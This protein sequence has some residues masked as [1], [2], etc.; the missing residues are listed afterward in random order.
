MRVLLTG[1]TGFVG[2][3]LLRALGLNTRVAGRSKPAGFEGE[4]FQLAAGDDFTEALIDIDVVIHCAARVPTLQDD[5]SAAAEFLRVNT[6]GTLR[7]AEQAAA[8]GVERLIFLS[9]VK[10]N[11]DGASCTGHA[12]MSGDQPRPECGYGESKHQ[13]ELGLRAIAN[14]SAMDVVIL[15]PP[16]VYGPGVGGN[17]K[18]LLKLANTGLPLPFGSVDNQ[19][20]MIFSGNL[21]D[22][23]IS[24]IDHP[25]A[26]NQ[27]FLV[28][29]DR[30][31]ST[32]ELLAL[33]RSSM[34]RPRRLLPVPPFLFKC[35]GKLL[36][37]TDVVDRLFGSLQVD[38]AVTQ[39]TLDWKPP[40]SIE[41]GVSQTVADFLKVEASK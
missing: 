26:A 29:D 24:C 12:Y 3:K 17:F 31:V 37:R 16:L 38:T 36:G 2:S 21:V 40:H 9:T 28:G 15:R 11:G 10:V 20:S 25:A 6:Q 13:A 33:M 22:L 34:Q 8:A 1:A 5:E 41:S 32:A 35:V 39:S 19:R 14:S 23:I 7:L 27:T 30:D 4:F 18:S